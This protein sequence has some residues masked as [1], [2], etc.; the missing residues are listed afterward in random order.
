M[1]IKGLDI[2]YIYTRDNCKK[3]YIS[4]S[5]SCSIIIN[6]EKLKEENI[7]NQLDTLKNLQT[8]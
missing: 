2:G 8:T 7:Q 6:N 1:T 4:G 3:E 5:G